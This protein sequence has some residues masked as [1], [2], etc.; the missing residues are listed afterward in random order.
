MPN[1][2]RH[3]TGLTHHVTR[4]VMGQTRHVTVR[5]GAYG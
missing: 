2:P 4:H 3:V 1:P 5:W